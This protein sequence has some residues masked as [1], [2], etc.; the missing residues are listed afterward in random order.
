LDGKG[1]GID[2]VTYCFEA[3]DKVNYRF[4]SHETPEASEKS[5]ATAKKVADFLKEMEHEFSFKRLY[6]E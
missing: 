5:D 4:F 3:S 2:G 6:I 1:G